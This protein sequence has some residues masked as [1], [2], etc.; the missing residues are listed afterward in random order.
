MGLR[1]CAFRSGLAVV[2]LRISALRL[3]AAIRPS[4]PPAI[5]A[6]KCQEPTT[7]PTGNITG[8]CR[9]RPCQIRRRR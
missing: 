5:T 9:E 2:P 1:I 3:S 8:L 6:G 7:R 4:M